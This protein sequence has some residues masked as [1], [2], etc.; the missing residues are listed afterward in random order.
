MQR[1]EAQAFPN[2]FY[3][4]FFQSNCSRLDIC[5]ATQIS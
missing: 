3:F 4:F 2:P 1:E 5:L